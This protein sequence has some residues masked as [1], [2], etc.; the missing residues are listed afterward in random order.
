MLIC[1]NAEGVHGQRKVGK[2]WYGVKPPEVF[3]QKF[4]NKG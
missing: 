3:L 1:P 2:P 4:F